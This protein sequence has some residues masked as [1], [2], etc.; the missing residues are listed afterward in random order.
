MFDFLQAKQT[1]PNIVASRAQPAS[2]KRQQSCV[3]EPTH[4][5]K[6]VEAKPELNTVAERAREI[7][8]CDESSL[9]AKS[10]TWTASLAGWMGGRALQ[11]CRRATGQGRPASSS[12]WASAAH[13][14]GINLSPVL[15]A[16]SAIWHSGSCINLWLFLQ[17]FAEVSFVGHRNPVF[18]RIS[19]VLWLLNPA[20]PP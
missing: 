16:W 17:A 6:V 12:V 7:A 14:L 8:S 11:A 18:S 9:T 2:A 13:H 3:T 10:S 15:C 1:L 19:L 4:L 5:Y 20:A